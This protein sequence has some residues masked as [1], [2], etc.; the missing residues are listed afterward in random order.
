MLQG[1]FLQETK[2]IKCAKRKDIK[3]IIF[4]KPFFDRRIPFLKFIITFFSILP[5]NIEPFSI[6]QS[7]GQTG[8]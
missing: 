1:L 6:V 7:S 5:K 2:K 8:E 4:T 3:R